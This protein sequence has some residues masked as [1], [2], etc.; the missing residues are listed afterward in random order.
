MDQLNYLSAQEL[1]KAHYQDL[2]KD[3]E[4]ERIFSKSR[5]TQ[6]PTARWWSRLAHTLHSLL[7]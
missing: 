5:R 6:K 2:L 1:M 4:K 3:A 7:P